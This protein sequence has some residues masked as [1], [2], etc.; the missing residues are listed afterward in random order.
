ME[1]GVFLLFGPL[2]A[3]AWGLHALSTFRMPYPQFLFS[4]A[5]VEE[6]VK[7]LGV[8]DLGKLSNALQPLNKWR[9]RDFANLWSS[10]KW[11]VEEFSKWGPS[12]LLDLVFKY[13]EAFCGRGL[14]YEDLVTQAIRIQIKRL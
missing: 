9:L 4:D 2:Y 7:Q 10:D 12:E 5:F 1:A 13:P 14:R 8:Y 3:S 6:K 11:S